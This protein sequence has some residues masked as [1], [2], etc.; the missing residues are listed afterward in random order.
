M[1]IEWLILQAYRPTAVRQEGGLPNP[2]RYRL[3]TAATK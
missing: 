2:G 3:L 1:Q